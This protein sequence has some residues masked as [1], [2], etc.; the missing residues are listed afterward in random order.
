[1]AKIEVDPKEIV[2]FLWEKLELEDTKNAIGALKGIDWNPFNDD[3]DEYETPW[4]EIG[5]NW[6]LIWD[7]AVSI[8]HTV[9]NLLIGGVELTD[10]QKHK[11][12]VSAL[13]RAIRLPFYLEPFDG[14]PSM[15]ASS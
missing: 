6:D 5:H 8:S 15:A 13:D 12:V 7:A 10:P 14:Q 1:M 11:V 3:D 9:G 4:Q 2:D